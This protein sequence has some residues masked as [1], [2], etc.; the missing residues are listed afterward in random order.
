MRILKSPTFTFIV[1]ADKTEFS[2]HAAIIALQS[3]ALHALTN[4]PM[5]EATSKTVVLEDVDSGTFVSF[6]QFAYYGDYETPASVVDAS[7]GEVRETYLDEEF[8]E[9]SNDGFV[10]T[11]MIHSS[12]VFWTAPQKTPKRPTKPY[13][14][15]SFNELGRRPA[16][17]AFL[18]EQFQSKTYIMKSRRECFLARCEPQ[19]NNLKTQ[20]F[21]PVLLR[22]AQLYSFA[23]KWGIQDLRRLTL[24]KLHKTLTMFEMFPSSVADIVA[25]IRYAFCDENTPD[26]DDGMDELRDLVLCFAAYQDEVLLLSGGFNELLEEGGSFVSNFHKRMMERIDK[27]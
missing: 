13:S 26:K 21:T 9:I 4:V 15:N 7:R 19:R 3:S 10:N 14:W 20:D 17:R 11:R 8:K 16:T 24:S 12:P 18:R 25:L 5:M 22:H 1:G 27:D 6:C 2:V 23:D